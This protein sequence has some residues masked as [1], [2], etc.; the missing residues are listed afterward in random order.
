MLPYQLN[1]SASSPFDQVQ[2][3]S[4]VHIMRNHSFTKSQPSIII[5]SLYHVKCTF[6]F[7]HVALTSYTQTA[8]QPH[9]PTNLDIFVQ[10]LPQ[11]LSKRHNKYSSHQPNG[12][13]DRDRDRVKSKRGRNKRKTNNINNQANNVMQTETI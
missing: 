7:I 5:K 13:T 2:C 1:P 9:R 6:N 8:T 10:R 4:V 12:G 3:F 11:T